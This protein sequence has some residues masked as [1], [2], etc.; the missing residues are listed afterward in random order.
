VTE[1]AGGDPQGPPD[2]LRWES[3]PEGP[4]LLV[5]DVGP[6]KVAFTSRHVGSSRGPYSSLD[7]AFNVGDDQV[8][9]RAN[10]VAVA[11]ALGADPGAWTAVDQVHGVDVLAVGVDEAGTGAAA[12]S[13]VQADA[14]VTSA[15]G[16]L[17]AVTVADC[18][19]ILVVGVTAPRVAA[20]HAGW[21]GV[22]GGVLPRALGLMGDPADLEIWVGAHARACCY[23]VD[24][25]LQSRFTEVFGPGVVRAD[26][27]L[28]LEACVRM[29]ASEAGV[30]PERVR[31]VP[32]CTICEHETF[33][34]YRAD[35][36]TTG[37]G[38]GLVFLP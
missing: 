31:S 4:R 5:G 38:A 34:S 14:M 26:G 3:S 19:P 24:E 16:A 23:R 22:I 29:Q 25:D 12:T 13:P 9:V 11:R 21:R 27:G 32:F 36:P 2:G 18:V 20:V 17:L 6:A 30:P 1:I 37:R 10:R 33:F 35:G 28:D 7:L 15:H 8:A